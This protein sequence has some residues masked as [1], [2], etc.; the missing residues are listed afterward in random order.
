MGL[1]S[2]WVKAK[3]EAK[4]LNNKKDVPLKSK[5]LGGALDT[6]EAAEKAKNKTDFPGREWAKAMQAWVKAADK[7]NTIVAGYLQALPNLAATA[8]AKEELKTHLT[9]KIYGAE[10]K[11]ALEAGQKNA[12]KIAAELAK[13][14]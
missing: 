9:F 14:K 13:P 3:A 2:D 4:K 6:F 10:L 11:P 8:E 12:Q 7:A 5:N 1:R